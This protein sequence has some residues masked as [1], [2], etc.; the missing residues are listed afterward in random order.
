MLGS[1]HHSSLNVTGWEVEQEAC[2]HHWKPW[3]DPHVIMPLHGDILKGKT[4]A[5]VSDH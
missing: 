2:R 5:N 3:Q 4:T 1:Q